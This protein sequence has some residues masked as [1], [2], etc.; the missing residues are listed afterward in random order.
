M[1]GSVNLG[2][3]PRTI[4]ALRPLLLLI[5]ASVLLLFMRDLDLVRESSTLGT[6]LLVPLQRVLA[7]T[8]S[9]AG[10]FL[11]VIGEIDDLRNANARLRGEV[12]QLTLENVRIREEAATA[13]Q[14]ARF[15]TARGTYTTVGAAVIARDPS[16]I[17][18]TVVIDSGKDSGVRTGNVVIA[19]RGVVGRVTEVGTNFARVLLLTDSA[20]TV[21]ALVQGSRATGIVSGQY[22][23]T[24]V[25]DWILQSE[26]VKLGDVVLTAGLGLGDEL[27][28]LYPKGLVIGTVVEV[29][30]S[31]VNAYIRT[32][33]RPA[34]DLRRLE[35][36]LVITGG[37]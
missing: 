22:G 17:L 9:G 6:Q 20:S 23:D 11:Q 31:E 13:R 19:D 16:A 1:N 34:V 33:V 18:R 28:S 7:D 12:D 21:S 35:R 25:M 15:D 4:G 30:R 5:G 26:P 2:R 24:L 27:R 29:S 8:G 14:V 3:A 37:T 10:R 36:V 32:I